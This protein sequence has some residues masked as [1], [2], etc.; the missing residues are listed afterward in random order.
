MSE[1]LQARAKLAHA[2]QIRLPV[3]CLT[4]A[5]LSLLQQTRRSKMCGEK[6]LRN[7]HHHRDETD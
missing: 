2:H 3:V 5:S 1:K 7:R 4:A 6:H